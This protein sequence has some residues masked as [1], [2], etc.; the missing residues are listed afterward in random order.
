MLNDNGE[1]GYHY[2][3]KGI[4]QN[5]IKNKANKQFN[6]DLMALYKHLYDGH[7]LK[8]DLTESKPCFKMNKDRTVSNIKSF[9][10]TVKA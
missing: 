4:P 5:A 2:R 6:G 7:T 9:T 1:I 10:R 3:M 8:F